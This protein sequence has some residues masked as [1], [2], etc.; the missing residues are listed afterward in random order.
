MLTTCISPVSGLAS[1]SERDPAK[2]QLD[3]ISHLERPWMLAVVAKVHTKRDNSP[4]TSG[5]HARGLAFKASPYCW[6]V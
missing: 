3:T 5:N 2:L 4:C 6:T 1:A